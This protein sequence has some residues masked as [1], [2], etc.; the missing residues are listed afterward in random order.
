MTLTEKEIFN[1]NKIIAIFMG[2][3]ERKPD[4]Q[5]ETIWFSKGGFSQYGI[6]QLK[7][8]SS[9]DWL[10]PVVEKIES[11]W[12]GHTQPI[13]KIAGAYCQIADNGGYFAKNSELYKDN[14]IGGECPLN[15][16]TKIENT[17]RVVVLFIEWYNNYLNIIK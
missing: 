13:V 8:H 9:W 10:M 14:Q 16:Y 11:I 7:Y 3:S 12:I 15:K 2:F 6:N 1:G 4:E 5:F 17:Y